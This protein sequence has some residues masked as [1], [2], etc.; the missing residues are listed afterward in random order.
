MIPQLLSASYVNTA[1]QNIIVTC[2]VVNA[3][4]TCAV[5]IYEVERLGW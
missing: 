4:D 2:E 5:W 3:A 1:E